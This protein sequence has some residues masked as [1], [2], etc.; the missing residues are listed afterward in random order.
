MQP[1]EW[2]FTT[3]MTSPMMQQPQV[4]NVSKCVSKADADDP[5]SFLGGDNAAGCAITRG[6]RAPGSY[7]WTIACEKQGVS[8]DRQGDVRPDPAR[9]RNPHDRRVEGR[10]PEDR[11]DQP[12]QGPLPRP[13]QGEIVAIIRPLAWGYSSAGRALAW[14]ARGQR[15]DPA[16]LH[17][18]RPCSNEFASLQSRSSRGLG[19][20]PFTAVTGVRIPVGTPISVRHERPLSTQSGHSNVADAEDEGVDA[21]ARRGVGRRGRWSTRPRL[22]GRV[23][24]AGSARRAASL[25][26]VHSGAPWECHAASVRFWPK[27]VIR[28]LVSTRPSATPHREPEAGYIGDKPPSGRQFRFGTNDRFRPRADIRGVDF[29]VSNS[30]GGG[31]SRTRRRQFLISAGALLASPFALAQKSVRHPVVGVLW[32]EPAPTPEQ[33]S[34]HPLA[35]RLRSS[36]GSKERISVVHVSAERQADRLAGLAADCAQES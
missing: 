35:K 26:Y 27:A 8:G 28:R 22:P 23:P 20:R 36:A 4:G 34:N 24:P 19:H 16:Y 30:S 32:F 9:K 18:S 3:T 17:H 2:Q 11:D 14:H 6:A 15:F 5:T 7:N 12:D 31:M 29:P 10:R 25:N 21:V 13:L 1:G 33:W